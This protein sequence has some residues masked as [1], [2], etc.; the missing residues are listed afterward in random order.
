ML[1]GYHDMNPFATSSSDAITRFVHP[2][3]FK[4]PPLFNGKFS[5]FDRGEWEPVYIYPFNPLA[6]FRPIFQSALRWCE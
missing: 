2:S 4:Y 6:A 3:V 5:L 1:T